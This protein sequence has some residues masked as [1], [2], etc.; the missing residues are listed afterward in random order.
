MP[1]LR[2]GGYRVVFPDSAEAAHA[3]IIVRCDGTEDAVSLASAA[4][5]IRLTTE[6]E[7]A[8][9][10]LVYRYDRTRLLDAM[11]AGIRRAGGR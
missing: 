4:P 10:D 8:E 3:D 9:P 1:L 5:V 6:P 11:R 7:P 2:S